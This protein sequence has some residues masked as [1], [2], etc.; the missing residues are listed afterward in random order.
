MIAATILLLLAPALAGEPTPTPRAAR[1]PTF[2]AEWIA[3]S[4]EGYDRLTLFRD[5]ELVWKTSRAGK[6]RVRR[7][8]L[9][10]DETDYFCG[11][12]ARDEF[13][14][15]P[16][17]LRTGLAG[18]FAVQSAVTLTRPD[19]SRKTIRFDELSTF[20]NE[21]AS[22]RSALEGLKGLFLAPLAPASRFAPDLL[23]P[24]MLLRRFDGHVFRVARVEKATGFV[25]VEGI[26]EPYSQFIKIEELRFQFAPPEPAK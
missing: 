9:P 12:F 26:N 3:Q 24:G 16:A 20:T 5:R 10:A 18:E 21:S 25:E 14:G 7:E 2:C 15:I 22:V 13:W 4:R 17:D 6:D 1:G 19:G 11:F 8:T 23:S